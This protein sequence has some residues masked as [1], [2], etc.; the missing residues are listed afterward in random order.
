MLK[1]CTK[2]KLP[3]IGLLPAFAFAKSQQPNQR[4]WLP[5]K[6]TAK[7]RFCLVQI[8]RHLKPLLLP[9]FGKKNYQSA[10]GYIKKRFVSFLCFFFR[11]SPVVTNTHTREPMA[12]A[13]SPWHAIAPAHG[14]ASAGSPLPLSLPSPLPLPRLRELLP[15][16]SHGRGELLLCHS[17]GWRTSSKTGEA[18]TASDGSY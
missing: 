12:A 3:L 8:Q 4:G 13:A 17:H 2:L 7:R 1:R 5:S 18:S 15:Y 9:A 10:T 11:P 14:R 6:A 16:P